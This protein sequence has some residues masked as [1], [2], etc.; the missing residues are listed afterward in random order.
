LNVYFLNILDSEK[1]I[2]YQRQYLGRLPE[3]EPYAAFQRIDRHNKKYISIE[4]L[5]YFLKENSTRYS[6][7]CLRELI[8]LYDKD[9]DNDA[10]ETQRL[11]DEEAL[12]LAQ[13]EAQEAEIL[14]EK[15]RIAEETTAKAT[16]DLEKKKKCK[17]ARN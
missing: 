5:K 14:A 4:D 3:F 16:A 6:D 11:A 12:R 13:E 9:N 2:E 15:H 8:K 17:L 1:S 10:T 7:I